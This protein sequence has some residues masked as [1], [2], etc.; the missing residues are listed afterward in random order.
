VLKYNK[1][2]GQ[3]LS[4]PTIGYPRNPQKQA[5]DIDHRPASARWCVMDRGLRH[6]G[7]NPIGVDLSL[8]PFDYL[9]DVAG[10]ARAPGGEKAEAN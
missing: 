8:V 10:A 3:K 2:Q 4:G 5:I 9:A 7:A 6:S 1:K